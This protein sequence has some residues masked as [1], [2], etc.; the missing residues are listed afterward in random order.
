M[1]ILDVKLIEQYNK[2]H[3][4][5]HYGYN[6]IRFI[7]LIQLITYEI[8]ANILLDYGSGQSNLYSLIQKKLNLQCDRYDPAIDKISSIPKKKYDLII[9]T[10]V[11]EHIPETDIEDVVKHIK[12]YSENVFFFIA[13]RT[14]AEILPNGENAHCTVRN[15]NWWLEKIKRV[16]PKSF[17][18][19]SESDWACAIITWKSNFSN[20]YEEILYGIRYK[21]INNI[22]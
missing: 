7:N 12:Y 6:S 13:T 8:D 20:I 21:Q 2:I 15:A 5:K 19:Y 4:I 9:N 11:L 22:R 16:F 14:A 1:P 3:K 18:V 10:D 17:L